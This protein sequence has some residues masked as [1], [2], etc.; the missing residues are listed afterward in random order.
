MR[1]MGYKRKIYATL[2]SV[3]LIAHVGTRT[4]THTYIHI[5]INT[6]AH[7]GINV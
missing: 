5:C 7:I 4:H 3:I 1:V 6:Y 2:T